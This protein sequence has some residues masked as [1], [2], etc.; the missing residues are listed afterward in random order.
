MTIVTNIT[1]SGQTYAAKPVR[2]YVMQFLGL[3]FSPDGTGNFQLNIDIDACAPLLEVIAEDICPPLAGLIGFNRSLNKY[4][5]RGETEELV[6]LC[7]EVSRLYYLTEID[8]L[9]QAKEPNEE[10]IASTRRRLEEIALNLDLL[11]GGIDESAYLAASTAGAQNSPSETQATP[12]EGID[13]DSATE[14]LQAEIKS[15]R[16][17]LASVAMEQEMMAIDA[18][19]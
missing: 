10:L 5:W 12:S 3:V 4:Y 14:A 11:R 17:Q 6:E 13:S 2:K 8:R 1:I 19:E 16:A 15:L 9:T 7:G 18:I